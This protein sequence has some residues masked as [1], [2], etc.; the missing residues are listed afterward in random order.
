MA[1]GKAVDINTPEVDEV[2][3][4]GAGDI[5]A[6]S[7]FVRMQTSPDPIIA[8][9]FAT[10]VASAS[11]EHPGLDGIPTAETIHRAETYATKGIT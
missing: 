8:A 3:P 11:V 1:D 10:Y 9:R 4:T 5:F 2:D 6:T 7:F